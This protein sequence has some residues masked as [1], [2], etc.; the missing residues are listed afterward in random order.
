MPRQK[1]VWKTVGALATV[2]GSIVA[3]ATL[4]KTTS[5]SVATVTGSDNIIAQG[6][7]VVNVNQSSRQAPQVPRAFTLP[8]GFKTLA[9]VSPAQH[10]Y[11]DRL[12]S[13]SGS[14]DPIP[15]G[16]DLWVY[17]Y[18]PGARRYYPQ[19]V[20]SIDSSGHWQKDGIVIGALD[21]YG[22]QF[23]L[24]VLLTNSD[25]SDYISAHK[26]RDLATLPS[27]IRRSIV[28]TRKHR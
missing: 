24:G 14:T 9:I 20:L 21:D 16:F 17:V 7:S 3:I 11:V 18:A 25:G 13:V 28:V 27:G 2:V 1:D 5:G 12:V 8:T 19:R 4:F 22:A 6:N 26:E 10:A 15:S 23:E